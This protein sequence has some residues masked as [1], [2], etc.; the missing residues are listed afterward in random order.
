MLMWNIITFWITSIVLNSMTTSKISSTSKSKKKYVF[1]IIH[2][3]LQKMKWEINH[4]ALKIVEK[5]IL[6]LKI[7][8]NVDHKI[9]NFKSNSRIDDSKINWQNQ[10]NICYENLQKLSESYVFEKL[11]VKRKMNDKMNYV[12]IFAH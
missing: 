7:V 4:V 1:K 12:I 9:Q 5:S 6:T 10:L 8:H 3:N 11:S 2:K